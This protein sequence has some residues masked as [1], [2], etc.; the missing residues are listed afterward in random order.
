MIK[1]KSWCGYKGRW[2]LL[3]WCI[4][5]VN[6]ESEI[7]H[8]LLFLQ[9]KEAAE[10]GHVLPLHAEKTPPNPKWLSAFKSMVFGKKPLTIGTQIPVEDTLCFYSHA[11]GS[12][13]A[14]I[15]SSEY[16]GFLVQFCLRVI[17]IEAILFTLLCLS[18]AIHALG[19]PYLAYSHS[20]I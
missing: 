5:I 16:S 8:G 14:C 18:L 1:S 15:L 12:S 10:T 2:R 19:L 20:E 13:W 3:F 7:V 9:K 11:L 6:A 17:Q 4:P